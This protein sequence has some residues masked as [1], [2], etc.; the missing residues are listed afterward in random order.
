MSWNT[1]REKTNFRG[2]TSNDLADLKVSASECALLRSQRISSNLGPRC[3]L[4][5]QESRKLKSSL[6]PQIRFRITITL[7]RP[8]SLCYSGV[9][10]SGQARSH[11]DAQLHIRSYIIC[12]KSECT[13]ASRSVCMGG[14][15]CAFLGSL[16][17]VTLIGAVVL[18]VLTF[19]FFFLNLWLPNKQ[20]N[21]SMEFLLHRSLTLL[22]CLVSPT[23]VFSS[24]F[25]VSRFMFR[26]CFCKARVCSMT[27]LSNF[28]N[29]KFLKPPH[30]RLI[31]LLLHQ[32]LF[33]RSQWFPHTN[34]LRSKR[35]AFWIQSSCLA[36]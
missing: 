31:V 6:W 7:C 28:V 25:S 20:L 36:R 9:E 11:R 5:T 15:N 34:Y 14:G 21:P 33:Y 22:Q 1:E 32:P 17:F 23:R 26:C 12:I 10:S 3:W 35:K 8:L 29:S 16:L 18:I 4:G 13:E 30:S 19:F 24:L 27:S 2:V